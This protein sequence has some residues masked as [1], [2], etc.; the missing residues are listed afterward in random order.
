MPMLPEGPTDVDLPLNRM[1]AR[2]VLAL[3]LVSGVVASFTLSR[4]EATAV[5]KRAPASLDSSVAITASAISVNETAHLHLV[6]HKN[7]VLH[8]QGVGY[9]T[10]HCPLAIQLTIS[11]TT[12]GILFTC[13]PHGGSISGTAKASFYVAGAVARFSGMLSINHGTG[14]YIHASGVALQIKGTI[15]RETY[16]LTVRVSGRMNT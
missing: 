16:A 4:A 15:R 7:A 2:V 11:S 14:A 3:A 10:F 5:N 6:S 9:G 1:F 8:E 12:V 13:T